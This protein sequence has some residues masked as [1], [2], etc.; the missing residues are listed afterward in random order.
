MRKIIISI[1]AMLCAF[2]TSAMAEGVKV[3]ID[4]LMLKSEFGVADFD[5]SA[6]QVRAAGA[7]SPNVD[8][9]GVLAFG[10]SDDS[11]SV[12]QPGVGNVTLSVQLANMLGIYAKLHTDASSKFQFFGRLGLA[13]VKYD[14]DG[15]IQG[16]GSESASYDD[17][18]LSFGI[19]AS[20]NFTKTSAIVAEYAVLPAVDIEGIED[21]ET[22][23]IAVGLQMAF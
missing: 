8:I 12:F 16:V 22:D 23:T 4:Y 2:S 14:L 17:A 9:E 1:V 10:I 20:F 21:M 19:G 18:G 7:V 13:I 3:E 5:T 11:Y 15:S 6:I